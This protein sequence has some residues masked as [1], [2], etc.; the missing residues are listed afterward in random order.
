MREAMFSLALISLSLC[1][2]AQTPSANVDAKLI[3]YVKNLLASSF[4]TRLPRVSLEYF[5]AYE[6][7]DAS[8]KWTIT[9]CKEHS[10]GGSADAKRNSPTCVQADFDLNNGSGLTILI[11]VERSRSQKS[12]DSS[13]VSLSVTGLTGNVRQIRSLGGLPME[14]HRVPS[15]TPKDLP[16]PGRA[17]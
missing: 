8:A 2:P 1:A 13:V 16:L 11:R 9:E 6:T 15:R 14:L 10:A 5:L 7:G 12:T 3:Q 17:S 4:D